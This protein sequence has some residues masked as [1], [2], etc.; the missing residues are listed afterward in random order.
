ME[1]EDKV[2][3]L[4]FLRTFSPELDKKLDSGDPL[5]SGSVF[6][7]RCLCGIEESPNVEDRDTVNT[8][9]DLEIKSSLVESL[10]PFFLCRP[11]YFTVVTPWS[12]IPTGSGP[13]LL[14]TARRTD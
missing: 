4:A 11:S 9:G 10:C 14:H 7:C 3:S 1:G 2:Q 12:S 13:S 8:V 6:F 5:L